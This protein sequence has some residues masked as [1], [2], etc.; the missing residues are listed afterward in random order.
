MRI[1]V[2]GVGFDNLTLEEALDK[3]S[4]IK[5]GYVVTPNPEI[6]WLADKDEELKRAL[7]DASLVLPDGVGIT[8]GAKILGRPLKCRV[9][10]I[11]FASAY[12]DRLSKTGGSVFLFGS[13]PGVAELAAD[14][15]RE[16]HPGINVC[17]TADGYFKDDAPIIAKINEANPDF[18][19]VCLGAPK[20][21]K[22]I[23]ENAGRLSVKLMAGLGGVLDVYAGIVE[24]APEAWCKSGFEWLY[25]LLKQPSRLGRMMKLPLFMFKVMGERIKGR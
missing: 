24:R 12:I 8:Y 19:L 13:K 25:R 16:M 10:G 7:E 11:E 4:D 6:V 9:P 1:D 3:A 5:G 14:K 22:W 23:H 18:L 20:Q 17:G 15:L 2:L 21:E